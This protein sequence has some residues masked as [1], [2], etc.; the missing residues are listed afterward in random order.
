[1]HPPRST[2]SPDW[3]GFLELARIL[4]GPNGCPWD[5]AQGVPGLA[6]HLVEEAYEV[7]HAAEASDPVALA[8]EL[9]DTF[10][11]LALVQAASE[12]ASGTPFRDL[13]AKTMAKIVHRHPHVFEAPETLNQRQVALRW[14][15]R[16]RTERT[17]AEHEKG[18]ASP[19]TSTPLGHLARPAPALPALLQ[20]LRVQERAASVGF[21]WRQAEDVLP[22]IEEELGEV[23]Q[24]MAGGSPARDASL[25]E[26]LGDLLF[27]VV[28]LCRMVRL[29]PELALRRATEKFRE[30][31]NRITELAAEN[32]EQIDTLSLER[33]DEYW[34]A[35]KRE[36]QQGWRSAAP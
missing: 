28:N 11:L 5:R 19:P 3:E 15:A 25:R 29:D 13:A 1:M 12:E 4:R 17:E 14:E 2:P 20:A 27:A 10:F 6:A 30:R 33:L 31:F 8:E 18:E 24:A 36:N 26:E 16:K 21:D 7:L 9:G 34:N 23:R 35:V 22:K 32:Q